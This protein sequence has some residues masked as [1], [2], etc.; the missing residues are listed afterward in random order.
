MNVY[1][2][3]N[4][5]LELALK[6]EE[7]EAC[8]HVLRLCERGRIQL[9][10]P[11]YCLA[12]PHETLTR[13]HQQRKRMK[14]E[15]DVQLGQIARTAT[16]AAQLMGFH[17]LTAVLITSAEQANQNLSAVRSRII[18]CAEIIPLSASVLSHSDDFQRKHDFS[19]QDALVYAS[20]RSHLERS[21]QRKSYFLCRDRHFDDQDVLEELLRYSCELVPR[22]D[23]G[24]RIINRV[25][26]PAA[27][28]E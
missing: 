24:H 18:Q 1:V 8:E 3:S 2:E 27:G 4:Y 19:P 28:S 15:L 12:E 6:Q 25:L 22:F 16:N 14:D 26:R 11:A 17:E 23:E 5:V 20:I 7:A 9:V 10:V 13:R 21:G